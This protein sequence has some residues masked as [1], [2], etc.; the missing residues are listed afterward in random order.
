MI[1]D[2]NKD[3]ITFYEA[4]HLDLGTLQY[5]WYRAIKEAKVRKQKYEEEVKEAKRQLE[6]N[7]KLNAMKGNSSSIDKDT[8]YT[9]EGKNKSVVTHVRS[10]RKYGINKKQ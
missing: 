3:K 5:L 10:S 4:L 7:K 8:I 9:I 1:C 6:E 2:Y